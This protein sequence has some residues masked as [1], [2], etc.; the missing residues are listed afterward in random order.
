MK[1]LFLIIILLFSVL[2]YPQ[3]IGEPIAGSIESKVRTYQNNQ[4]KIK[5]I[6][7]ELPLL[8]EKLQAKKRVLEEEL[9]ALYK[10]RDALIAD[11]KVGARCSQCGGW[12]S[13]FEKRGENFEKHLG[14]VKGYA[15]P[16]TT[17]EL[18]AI[19]KEYAE[20][21]AIKKVQIQNL[22][23]NDRTYAQKQAELKKLKDAND[24]ICDELRDLSN[25]YQTKVIKEGKAKIDDWAAM[26][27][28]IGSDILINH[29]K[30]ALEEHKIKFYE[31]QLGVKTDSIN[32]RKINRTKEFNQQFDKKEI[33]RNQ[34]IQSIENKISDEEQTKNQ[35]IEQLNNT[36]QGIEN[37]LLKLDLDIA[38]QAGLED[39]LSRVKADILTKTTFFDDKMATL[40]TNIKR[41]KDDI[42]K[43]HTEKPNELKQ[44]EDYHNRMIAETKEEYAAK[45][46]QSNQ[47]I[48]SLRNAM[49][50]DQKLYQAQLTK[51]KNSK[52]EYRRFIDD[53]TFRMVSSAKPIACFIGNSASQDTQAYWNK[54]TDCI[55]KTVASSKD[56]T[57]GVFNS[58]CSEI[59]KEKSFIKYANYFKSLSAS[60]RDVVKSV[61]NKFW[62]DDLQ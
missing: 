23:K 29:D 37:D 32:K 27:M 13:E 9:N 61:S 24:K 10:E 12:K 43:S 48:T 40:T 53:E 16:A 3:T 57:S 19:R 52:E 50:S 1:K 15:I 60:E 39:N 55:S 30:I 51:F 18:E 62:F 47:R 17:G 59:P 5:T 20:K 26:L 42:A 4:D 21:A 31:N 41:L 11:M 25:Q 35:V 46:K 38:T 22:E 7:A 56:I 2:G 34:E 33:T 6:E 14:D 49:E 44:I 45:I 28:N 58:Y 36:K 54:V 8:L